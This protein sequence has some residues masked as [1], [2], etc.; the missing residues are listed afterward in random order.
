MVP[1]ADMVWGVV[2]V[3]VWCDVMCMIMYVMIG[4]WGATQEKYSLI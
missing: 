2:L 3:L 4:L 1:N